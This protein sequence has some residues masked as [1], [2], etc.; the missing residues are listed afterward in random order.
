VGIIPIIRLNALLFSNLNCAQIP[1]FQQALFGLLKKDSLLSFF[2]LTINQ[3][4]LYPSTP[5]FLL[6]PAL[7]NIGKAN[8]SKPFS[9]FLTPPKAKA[10]TIR[11]RLRRVV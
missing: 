6:F 7:H 2:S 5:S 1:P 8:Y 3:H 4:F 11:L 10:P 9:A